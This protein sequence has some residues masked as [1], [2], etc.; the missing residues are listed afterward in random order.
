M[1]ISRIYFS[2]RMIEKDLMTYLYNGVFKYVQL[3][4]AISIA[5]KLDLESQYHGRTSH[6]HIESSKVR[7]LTCICT[8]LTIAFKA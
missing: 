7:D 1:S 8:M 2:T 5:K 4:I 6:V 3:N